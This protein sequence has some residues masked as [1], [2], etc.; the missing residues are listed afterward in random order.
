MYGIS[1]EWVPVKDKSVFNNIDVCLART[2]NIEV[3][4]LEQLYVFLASRAKGN[5]SFGIRVW[6]KDGKN[7]G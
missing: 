3:R 5:D 4:V 6:R 7:N 2:A 1:L